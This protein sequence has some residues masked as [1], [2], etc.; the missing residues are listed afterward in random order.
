MD[1]NDVNMAEHRQRLNTV[2]FPE[3]Q[4][5][6]FEVM[7][8]ALFETLFG[9]EFKTRVKTLLETMHV[10]RMRSHVYSLSLAMLPDSLGQASAFL[11]WLLYGE[12]G[13]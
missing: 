9:T 11:A 2:D 13:P 3:E 4:E 7:L 5:G 1:S 12:T 10:L 6:V 8:E